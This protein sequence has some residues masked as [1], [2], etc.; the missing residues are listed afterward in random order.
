M[1][2]RDLGFE[3]VP[4]LPCDSDLLLEMLHVT[5]VESFS[6]TENLVSLSCIVILKYCLCQY[7]LHDFSWI[8]IWSRISL[9]VKWTIQSMALCWVLPGHPHP[10]KHR[11]FCWLVSISTSGCYVLVSSS[12]CSKA[13]LSS[14]HS[15]Q[16]CLQQVSFSILSLLSA[17]DSSRRMSVLLSMPVL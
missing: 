6:V 8:F 10:L 9:L 7:F 11:G 1:L 3:L 13:S 5:N 15:L 12:G 14:A 17:K 2:K 16:S 4:W